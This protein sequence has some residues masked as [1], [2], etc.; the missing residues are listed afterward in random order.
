MNQKTNKS[1][2]SGALA[3]LGNIIYLALTAHSLLAAPTDGTNIPYRGKYITGYQN[4]SIFK[5][6]LATPYGNIES[7]QNYYT[8]SYGV[9]DWLT[10]DG[11]VGLGDLSL[12]L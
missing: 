3:I 8:L 6:D 7:F 9:F 12:I 2:A 10:L 11:K 4:N 1:I 5:H